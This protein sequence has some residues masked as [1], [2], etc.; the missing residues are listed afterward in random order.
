MVSLVTHLTLNQTANMTKLKQI[1]THYPEE[2]GILESWVLDTYT[3]I[4]IARTDGFKYELRH[5]RFFTDDC[6]GPFV[7]DSIGFY[8]SLDDAMESAVIY[9]W[10]AIPENI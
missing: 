1:F 6:M 3:D 10:V 4:E 2:K 9:A 7:V 5:R 8:D